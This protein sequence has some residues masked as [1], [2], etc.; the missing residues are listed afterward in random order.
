VTDDLDALNAL[1]IELVESPEFFDTNK[2]MLRALQRISL[3]K[4]AIDN[5]SYSTLR[6]HHQ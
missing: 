6:K 4:L 1:L 2:A 5:P 3:S